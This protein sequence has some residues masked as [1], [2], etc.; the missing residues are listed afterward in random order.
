MEAVLQELDGYCAECTHNWAC[1][2]CPIDDA[3]RKMVWMIMETRVQALG[4]S[5][6]RATA[7]AINMPMTHLR[8]L[9]GGR[10]KN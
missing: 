4:E 2:G 3:K 1:E 9:P 8:L 10:Q 6:D 7:E 5:L